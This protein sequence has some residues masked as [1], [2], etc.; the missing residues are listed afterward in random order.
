VDLAKFSAKKREY[1]A[2][3][4]KTFGVAAERQAPP[5]PCNHCVCFTLGLMASCLYDLLF[6]LGSRES[7][8]CV[9][10]CDKQEY[11]ADVR[12]TF[13]VAAER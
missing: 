12:K 2:D 10:A 7:D 11:L 9:G 4:R 5:P 13:G 1:L 6:R 8:V 3:V